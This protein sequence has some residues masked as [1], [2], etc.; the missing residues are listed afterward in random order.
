MLKKTI[1]Y[2][3]YDG[4]VRTE[5]HYFNLT[6][7]ELMEMQMSVDG[8]MNKFLNK[9][10][11]EQDNVKLMQY[12]KQISL[13]SYGIK[14]D[15]GKRF[16]KSPEISEAFSQTG[17]YDELFMELMSGGEQVVAA[18]TNGIIPADLQTDIAKMKD[19]YIHPV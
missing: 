7:A 5:D 14:S 12:F 3:D 10:I 9:I 18:F 8:G 1:T 13:K 11:A 16:I 17:A 15:D 19:S 6:K 4:N 2:T